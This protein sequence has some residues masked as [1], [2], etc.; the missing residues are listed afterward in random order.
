M[1]STKR[2]NIYHE[3]YLSTEVTSSI[4]ELSFR[5]LKHSVTQ[6]GMKLW[7][8]LSNRFQIWVQK[9]IEKEIDIK[10]SPKSDSGT[11]RETT[12]LHLSCLFSAYDRYQLSYFRCSFQRNVILCDL[13]RSSKSYAWTR[14]YDVPTNVLNYCRSRHTLV[15]KIV[16]RLELAEKL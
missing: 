10:M 9:E 16:V 13:I 3:S 15:I 12:F 11:S 2:I 5:N 14:S 1:A 6:Q 4:G 7:H 8:K